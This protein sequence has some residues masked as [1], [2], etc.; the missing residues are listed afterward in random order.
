MRQS[1]FAEQMLFTTVRVE[2]TRS[3]GKAYVGTAFVVRYEEAGGRLFLVTNKHV[4]AD[5]TSGNLF[6]TEQQDGAPVLGSKITVIMRGVGTQWIGHPDPR[7]DVSVAPL[8]ESFE[9]VSG[10]SGNV[11]FRAIPT[12]MFADSSRL[13][14]LDPL[15]EIIFVGYPVGLY[16][17][18]NLLPITR[19]GIT[20]TH[21]SIDYQ[22]RP[23]FLID[24][25]VFPGSSGSPIFLHKPGLSLDGQQLSLTRSNVFLGVVAESMV[26]EDARAVEQL[27]QQS[28]QVV[29]FRQM[30]D[31]G[32]V[33]KARTVVETMKVALGA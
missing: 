2:T 11:Y 23:I 3:D 32:V 22:G 24:A 9:L 21:P 12:S 8:D 33:F 4:V 5:M 25:S 29:R 1:T 14:A 19:Q 31:I 20:A 26:L 10:R 17:E 28:E 15:E 18:Y 6:F 13:Q 30:I 16:D 27:T 7:V